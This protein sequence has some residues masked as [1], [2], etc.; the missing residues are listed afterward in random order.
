[1]SGEVKEYPIL[2][3]SETSARDD[4]RRWGVDYGSA[5]SIYF[6]GHERQDVVA[7]RELFVNYFLSRKENY[8]RYDSEIILIQPIEHPCVLIFHDESTFRS[9]EQ[10]AKRWFIKGKE[11]FISKGRGRSIMVSDFLVAHPIFL[12]PSFSFN[13]DIWKKFNKI[14]RKLKIFMA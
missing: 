7:D 11:L 6:Q 12:W 2:I 3:R 4:L 13:Q 8:Y 5:K 1:M 10:F 9:G 14:I